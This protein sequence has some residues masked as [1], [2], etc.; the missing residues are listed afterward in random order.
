MQSEPGKGSTFSFNLPA[1][2]LQQILVHYVESARLLEKT[3]DLRMLNIKPPDDADS[4][5]LRRLVCSACYPMD[6]V[7]QSADDKSLNALGV[8]SNT[9]KWISRIREAIARFDRSVER[10]ETELEI[11]VRGPWILDDEKT[12]TV[13]LEALGVKNCYV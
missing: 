3:G 8:C 9:E 11:K 1:N 4:A 10:P 6:I 5:M 13:L 7:M 12:P 2:D